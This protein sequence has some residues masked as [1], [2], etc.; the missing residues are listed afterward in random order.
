MNKVLNQNS[1]YF[2]HLFTISTF[3]Y[4]KKF[5]HHGVFGCGKSYSCVMGFGL[6]CKKLKDYGLTGLTFILCGKTQQTVKKNVCNTLTK[7]FGDNFKYDSSRKDGIMKDAVLF[8]QY[9][10]ILGFNDTGSEQKWRGLSDVFG[11]YHDECTLCTEEQ[12]NFMLGRIRGDWSNLDVPDGVVPGFYVG[13]CN[14]DHPNHHIKKKIDENKE[15]KSMQWT[16]ENACWNGAEEYYKGLKYEY[17]NNE[18]FYKRFLLGIWLGSEGQVYTMF[19]PRVHI[20]EVEDINIDY[21]SMKRNIISIDYGSDHPT[22]ILLISLNYN[23][24]YIVS[25]EWKLRGV[26]P[27]DIADRVNF[28]LD[29]LEQEGS[30]CSGVYIDPSAKALKDE[31]VKAGIVYKNA[32]NKHEDGIGTIKSFLSLNKLFITSNCENLIAEMYSYHYKES[33]SETGKDDVEKI[34]DDFVDSL[35]YGVYTDS[36]VGDQ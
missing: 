2:N 19:N 1:K 3:G 10:V 35:R 17:R 11:V 18:L 30:Y 12:F 33:N 36:V 22:A 21:K 15:Y 8:G 34:G 4:Y 29:F 32:L 14:P 25:K 31:F 23:G 16:M 20:L 6:L 5:I 24:I 27:S 28:I 9:I 13:S 26:A 7:I